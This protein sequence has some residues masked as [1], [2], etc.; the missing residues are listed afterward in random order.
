MANSESDKRAATNGAKLAFSW[1]VKFIEIGIVA[2]KMTRIDVI[3]TVLS[4]YDVIKAVHQTIMIAMLNW[5]DSSC[6]V[7]K[8][9]AAE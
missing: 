5:W 2:H 6:A 1:T 9:E 8:T 4:T 3:G 7:G